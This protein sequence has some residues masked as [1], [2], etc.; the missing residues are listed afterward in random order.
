M[1]RATLYRLAATKLK[2][3]IMHCNMSSEIGSLTSICTCELDTPFSTNFSIKLSSHVIMPLSLRWCQTPEMYVVIVVWASW[4]RDRKVMNSMISSLHVSCNSL[5]Y[6]WRCLV[7]ISHA[8]SYTLCVWLLCTKWIS[9]SAWI[10]RSVRSRCLAVKVTVLCTL[11][12]LCGIP[13]I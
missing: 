4:P 10:L 9:F 7:K 12:L 5:S 8:L 11:A 1:Y 6:S 3:T 2:A 13:A